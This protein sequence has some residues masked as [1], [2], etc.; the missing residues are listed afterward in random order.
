MPITLPPL[1]RRSFLQA[2]AAGAGLLLTGAAGSQAE[3][4]ADPHRF[5]LLS[6]THVPA[7]ADVS[8]HGTNMTENLRWVVAEL[9]TLSPRPAA[10]LIS[11][12]CAFLHG[13]PE[14]YANLLALVQPLREAGQPLHLLLGNHDHR[15]RIANALPRPDARKNALPDRRVAVIESPR[16][17][18]FLL[19]SL[20]T[21]NRTPGLLGESQLRWLAGELDRRDDRPAL[22]VMHHNPDT[23]EK[24]SGLTD[25]D[26]LMNVVGPRRHVQAVFFGH[27]HAWSHVVRNDGLHLVN[28]P[29]TA[30]VFVMGMPNGWVDARLGER[31]MTLE[32]RC[33]DTEHIQQGEKKT[34]NWRA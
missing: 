29:P 21:T 33:L 25:T 5:A 13:L 2:T 17:N 4:P 15:E 31:G 28:L 11:G 1:S 32:L 9:M 26:A 3:S 14:D 22:I 18:W 7:S 8:A 20:I 23:R 6:D 12:D 34:L 10:T 30:Y 16:A 19:D 24:T 27:T